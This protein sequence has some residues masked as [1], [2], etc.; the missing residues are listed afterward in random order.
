LAFA[1]AINVDPDILIVDEALSVGD[2]L[3]QRKC[4]SRIESIRSSG[5][6]ILFVSHSGGQVVELCDRALLMDSGE[7]IA[8][9]ISKNIVG[10]Y[11]KL[12][13]A[14]ADRREEIRNKII[15]VTTSQQCGRA[16]KDHD[17]S[18]SLLS[19]TQIDFFDP[20]LR[21]Q[22]TIGY[23]ERGAIIT[24]PQLFNLAGERV[25]CVQN[26]RFYRFKY[27]VKFTA[28][29]NNVLF[30]MLIKTTSGVELGGGSARQA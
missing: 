17:D 18:K 7:K 3:F 6:T 8:E 28:D 19:L 20:H 1:V 25:N 14:P 2:E 27:S 16:E 9:G 11:Q 13:Y 24:Q 21:S 22:S 5:A 4:L 30:G 15:A 26:G 29:A 10:V 23:E 12:L